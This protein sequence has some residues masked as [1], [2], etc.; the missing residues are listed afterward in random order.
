M[1][2]CIRKG[3]I[4]IIHL[5][6]YY[7]QYIADKK[8]A[9]ISRSPFKEVSQLP[10]YDLFIIYQNGKSSGISSKADLYGSDFS[11]FIGTILPVSF[12]FPPKNWMV[13]AA[14]LVEYLI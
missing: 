7:N 1:G 9:T 5:F 6:I 13:S 14:I 2:Q 8:R 11:A 4:F 3:N 10:D 12:A